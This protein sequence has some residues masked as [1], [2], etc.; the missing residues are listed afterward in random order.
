MKL[1]MITSNA[2]D[3]GAPIY[4]QTNGRWTPKLSAGYPLVNEADRDRLL[5]VARTQ[6][7]RIACDPYAIE[8]ERV[9]LGHLA[10]VSL[11]ERIR[12]EG[13]TIVTFGSSSKTG[14]SVARRQVAASA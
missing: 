11:R 12:A 9:A 13:P 3:D 2:T 6:Q 8:V 7:Q 14:T 10:A 1:W 4:L 5:E